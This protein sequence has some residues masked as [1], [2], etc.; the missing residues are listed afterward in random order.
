[1][2]WQVLKDIDETF[3]LHQFS[4]TFLCNKYVFYGM[5]F[6]EDSNDGSWLQDNCQDKKF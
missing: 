1:M 2:Q 5:G 3:F 6:V 4:S